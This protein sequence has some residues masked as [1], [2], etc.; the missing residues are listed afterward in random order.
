MAVHVLDGPRGPRGVVKPGLI[1]MAQLSAAPIFPV[2]ISC[3][4]AWILNS[5]DRTVIPKPFSTITVR[6]DDPIYVPEKL[7]DETF[8]KTR[9]QI[10]QHMK[11][12]Q[13]KDDAEK[14]WIYPL[15]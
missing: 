13:N 2:Y 1:V 3:D 6:W 14:G 10:E 15:L 9:K 8:E 4:S 7:D 5:W 12:N 11:E